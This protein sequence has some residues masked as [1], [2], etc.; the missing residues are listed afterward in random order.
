MTMKSEVMSA[1]TPALSPGERVSVIT[2]PDNFSIL[3][4]VTDS[5]S[6]AVRRTTIQHIAWL[7]TR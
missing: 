5:V 6:L 4:A 3:I 7:K 1:L 2:V